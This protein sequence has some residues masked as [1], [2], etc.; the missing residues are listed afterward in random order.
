MDLSTLT[1]KNLSFSTERLFIRLM[2]SDDLHYFSQL[3]DNPTLMTYIGPIIDKSALTEKFNKRTKCLS[4]LTQWFTLLVFEHSTNA[5][6]GSVGFLLQDTDNHR[7][8]IGYIALE[9]MQGKGFITEA[10]QVMNAFI[11]NQLKAKKIVASCAVQNIASWKV[12]EKLGLEREGNLK[13]DFHVNGQWYDS[14]CY[15][16]VN[17]NP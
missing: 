13:S 17:P 8:E 2:T 9:S 3:Q 6:C 16:L 12:M 10:A 14:Y 5:F 11:F 4:D 7:V 1:T 15:G